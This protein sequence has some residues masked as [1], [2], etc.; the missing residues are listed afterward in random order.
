MSPETI[1]AAESS[2]QVG[3]ITHERSVM[4]STLTTDPMTE[5][6]VTLRARQQALGKLEVRLEDAALDGAGT[7]ALEEQVLTLTKEIDDLERKKRA[8]TR[9]AAKASVEEKTAAKDRAAA[10]QY[11]LAS[12]AVER[13]QGVG[14]KIAELGEEAA[15]LLAVLNAAQALDDEL[16][17][18]E[19]NKIRLSLKAYVLYSIRQWPGC[20]TGLTPF[21]KLDA[22]RFEELAPTVKK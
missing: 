7:E 1:E 6:E 22:K 15:N 5:L 11:N 14:R 17:R 2:Q 19:C 9:R 10:I 4:D 8:L 12:Q 20:D 16:L 21:L 18:F 13:V 3:N